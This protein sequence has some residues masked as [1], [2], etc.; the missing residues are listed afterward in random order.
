MQMRPH[1][2]NMEVHTDTHILLIC[3]HTHRHTHIIYIPVL[4]VWE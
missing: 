1:Y 2:V 4:S 3:K